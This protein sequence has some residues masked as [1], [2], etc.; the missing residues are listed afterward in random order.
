MSS[1]AERVDENV[2][3]DIENDEQLAN[4][5]EESDVENE[6]MTLPIVEVTMPTVDCQNR[7][8]FYC[9]EWKLG[10]RTMDGVTASIVEEVSSSLCPDLSDVSEA[11]FNAKTEDEEGSHYWKVVD[12]EDCWALCQSYSDPDHEQ[13]IHISDL[14]P[15]YS[16]DEE[17]SIAEERA[18]IIDMYK[19]YMDEIFRPWDQLDEN[20]QNVPFEPLLRRRLN[21][22]SLMT[23]ESIP[24]HICYRYKQQRF[25]C[26]R[27]EEDRENIYDVLQQI[28]HRLRLAGEEDKHRAEEEKFYEN[29]HN[30]YMYYYT[31]WKAH[32]DRRKELEDAIWNDYEITKEGRSDIVRRKNGPRSIR[33][34][35]IIHHLVSSKHCV[36]DIQ[37]AVG[38]NAVI[39]T[40]NQDQLS[41]AL[42]NCF[43]G[44]EVVLFPGVYELSDFLFHESITVRGAG[45]SADEVVILA[46]DSENNFILADSE[47]ITFKNVT[48]EARRN[49]EG[50]IAVNGGHCVI[51]NCIINCDEITRGVI[52]RPFATCEINSTV[53]KGGHEASVVIEPAGV[54]IDG[55]DNE[56]SV[57]PTLNELKSP[58]IIKKSSASSTQ[59]SSVEPSSIQNK[60]QQTVSVGGGDTVVNST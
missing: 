16:G 56:F 47:N 12:V 60:H 22:Y 23:S 14:I 54:L 59:T 36:K 40:Y 42:V 8:W 34:K 57:A 55:K 32:A 15:V 19:F 13:Q 30:E 26:R 28:Q 52:V 27:A 45:D 37:K 18:L 31:I 41:V 33:E 48:F 58:T 1:V 2:I 44:D 29:V 49:T 25:D 11:P 3:E 39:E 51:E 7:Y 4:D 17:R 50:C 20:R 43:D 6:I 9:R 21:F 46:D 24:R 53:I 35:S 10:R 5:D 38:D